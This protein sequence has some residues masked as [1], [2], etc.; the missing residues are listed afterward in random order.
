MRKGRQINEGRNIFFERVA[1]QQTEGN[2]TFECT[3]WT[4]PYNEHRYSTAT[5]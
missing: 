5:V 2:V 1:F 3:L 4:Q